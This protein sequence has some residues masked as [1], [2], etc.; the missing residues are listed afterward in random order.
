MEGLCL[1]T[2]LLPLRLDHQSIRNVYFQLVLRNYSSKSLSVTKKRV[3]FVSQKRLTKYIYIVNF[4]NPQFNVSTC[5]SV[6][7]FYCSHGNLVG[8]LPSDYSI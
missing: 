4:T 1:N 7:V 3:R 2:T 8:V 5:F 6:S